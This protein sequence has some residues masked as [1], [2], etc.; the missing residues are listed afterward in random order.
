MLLF[1]KQLDSFVETPINAV[2]RA[3]EVCDDNDMFALANMLSDSNVRMNLI[4]F[5]YSFVFFITRI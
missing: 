2:R 5:H 4:R 1:Q 3:E